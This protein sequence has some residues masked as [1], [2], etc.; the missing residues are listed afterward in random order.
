[1]MILIC[2]GFGLVNRDD[3]ALQINFVHIHTS[4]DRLSRTSCSN[5]IDLRVIHAVAYQVPLANALARS[6]VPDAHMIDESAAEDH[7]TAWR[8]FGRFWPVFRGKNRRNAGISRDLNTPRR[9]V[10]SK[11]KFSNV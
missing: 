7:A 11:R 6:A 3:D 4:V 1:M 8:V 5:C 10:F 9:G 2:L